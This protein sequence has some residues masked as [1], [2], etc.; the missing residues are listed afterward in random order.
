MGRL[1]PC[2]REEMAVAVVRA[3]EDE[4]GPPGGWRCEDA[5]GEDGGRLDAGGAG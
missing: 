2:T 5:L 4:A 1:P 3:V